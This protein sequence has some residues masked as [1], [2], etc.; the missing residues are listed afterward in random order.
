MAWLPIYDFVLARSSNIYTHCLLPTFMVHRC[1][2]YD[3]EYDLYGFFKVKT[4]HTLKHQWIIRA[5]IRELY[6]IV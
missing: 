6:I 4:K 3:F 2:K 5:T 1:L